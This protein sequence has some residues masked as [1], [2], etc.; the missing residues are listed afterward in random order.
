MINILVFSHSFD[1]TSA[2][3]RSRGPFSLLEKAGHIKC[4]Y[5]TTI[6]WWNLVDQHILYIMDAYGPHYLA[7]TAL[8]QRMNMK[9]ISDYDDDYTALSTHNHAYQQV[10]Q[11]Q[12]NLLKIRDMADE[13]WGVTQ[14]C[15]KKMGGDKPSYVIPNAVD[16]R[17]YKKQPTS[18]NK[19][20]FYRGFNSH[21]FDVADVNDD[22]I[23]IAKKYPEW[24]LKFCSNPPQSD[25]ETFKHEY[26]EHMD[27]ITYHRYIEKSNP[28]IM[29]VPLSDTE[30]NRSKA[31]QAWLEGTWIG[32]VTIAPDFP[33]WQLPGIVNYKQGEFKDAIDSLIQRDDISSL[34]AESLECIEEN[35]TVEKVN[36]KRLERFKA[37]CGSI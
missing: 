24:D 22:L 37:L 15:V 6:N 5:V 21:V 3:Q 12:A 28:R 35:Y 8:A 18:N 16:K 26:I 29:I 13:V 31:P 1:H 25:Y 30:F 9:I 11:N 7:A 10:K 36:E 33:A 19:V 2:Q 34:R 4:T 23:Y 32:A 20:I 14:R 17:F 27:I